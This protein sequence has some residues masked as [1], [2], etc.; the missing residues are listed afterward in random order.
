MFDHLEHDKMESCDF[1]HIQSHEKPLL[2]KKSGASKFLYLLFFRWF[3]QHYQFPSSLENI[4]DELIRSEL[5]LFD[6]IASQKELINFFQNEK[7]IEPCFTIRILSL[8]HTS[9]NEIFDR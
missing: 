8:G 1:W 9:I 2:Q 6:G 7:T 4:P 5:A 3:E